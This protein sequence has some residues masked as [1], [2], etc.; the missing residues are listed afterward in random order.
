MSRAG[1]VRLSWI[2]VTTPGIRSAG[3][4]RARTFPMLSSRPPVPSCPRHV[5]GGGL[6][7]GAPAAQRQ[8][9]REIDG[10]RRLADA[11]FLIGDCND[12]ERP[13]GT[14]AIL[15]DHILYLPR[16]SGSRLSS[17]LCSR[18]ASVFSDAKSTVFALSITESSTKIGARVRSASAIA[19]LGRASIAS[20]S[21]LSER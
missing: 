13:G 12:H 17:H 2:V 4:A 15:T 20:V 7:R 1:A 3:V 18:S 8:R 16:S 9:G 5:D 21:P 14:A 19:S 6:T 10:G 11:P